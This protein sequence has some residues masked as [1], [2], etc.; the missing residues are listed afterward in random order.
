M[1]LVPSQDRYEKGG[2]SCF[3]TGTLSRS[4]APTFPW[5]RTDWYARALRVFRENVRRRCPSAP[6]PVL[7]RERASRPSSC[8]LLFFKV[9]RVAATPPLLP[10]ECC[11]LCL[12]KSVVDANA[13]QGQLALSVGA[14]RTTLFRLAEIGRRT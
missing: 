8:F 4:S 7:S 1:I 11:C 12:R 13:P 3:C 6:S 9:V 10:L 14:L 2:F 5:F